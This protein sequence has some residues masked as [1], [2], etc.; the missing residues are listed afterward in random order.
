MSQATLLGVYASGDAA[1]R[2]AGAVRA[3]GVGAAMTYAPMA[4]PALLAGAARRPSLVR[5]CTLLGGLAGGAAGIAF[6]AYTMLDAGLIVGGKPIVSIPPLV[7]IGFELAMLGAALGGLAGF[8]LLSRLPRRLAP[9]LAGRGFTDDRYGV[10]VTCT[11]GQ[12]AGARAALEQA[13][14]EEVHDGA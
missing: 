8:L 2:A 1:A 14:A 12:Q 9:A 7:V 11:P 5:L 13:G 10:L 3:A 4:D 6:P